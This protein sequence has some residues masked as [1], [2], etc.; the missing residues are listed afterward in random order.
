MFFAMRT[1]HRKYSANHTGIKK[2]KNVELENTIMLV[3]VI[4][5]K[6]KDYSPL[7]RVSFVES[8]GTRNVRVC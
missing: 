7:E 2:N 5:D 4:A 1:G 3:S 6:R 8:I